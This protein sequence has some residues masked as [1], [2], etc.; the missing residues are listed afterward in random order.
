MK[1]I[2]ITCAAL[3]LGGCAGQEM[4]DLHNYLAEVKA[5]APTPIDPIPQIR[6]AETFLYLADNRRSPF[7]PSTA[8]ELVT[9]NAASASG[10]RPDPNRRREEL[11]G[12][13]LDTLKMVGTL[14]RESNY[15]GLVQTR[16][17][18]IHRV[19]AGNYLGK[20]YGRILDINE[21]RISLRE[22]V[23]DG[24]GGYL[25]RQ[26]SLALGERE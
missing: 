3:L 24:A 9:A 11:E 25:E 8:S 1:R 2:W 23:Q 4:Q 18:M 26:A 17:R 12:Y 20:N 14:K 16:D 13:P 19:E 15:W 6:E 5:R 10:P 22:L 7:V 21:N